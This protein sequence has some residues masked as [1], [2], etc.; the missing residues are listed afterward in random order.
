MLQLIR[1]RVTSIF[2]KALFVLLIASFAV[3]GI[4]DIFLGSPTGKAAIEVGNVEI[5]TAEVLDEFERV[6]RT[7]GLQMTAQEAA[8]IGLL[9]QVMDDLA[10]RALFIAES[11]D[12]GLAVGE[13]L[14]RQRIGEMPAFKDQTG[15][16]NPDL[17]R[18]VLYRAQ[19][20]EDGFVRLLREEIMRD[21]IV[22]AVTAGV[23]APAVATDVLYRYRNERR[24]AQLVTL[25][26]K[27][28]P[29]PAAPTD[30]Q[31]DS[32]YNDNKERYRAPEYRSA[33]VLSLT[34]EAL[35]ADIEV[36]EDRLRESYETRLDEF[37]SEAQRTVDQIF[38][39]DKETAD[40]AAAA[41]NEGQS[42]EAV[43][44][45]IAD[46]PAGA[47]SL[48]TVTRTDLD[49]TA[50]ADSI[51]S[52]ELNVP[53]A[54]VE[55]DLGW[56]IFRITDI[57]EESTQP[58]ADVKEQLKADIAQND[59]LDRIFEIANQIEDALA[60]GDTIEEAAKAVDVDVQTFAALDDQG[61][62]A[63]G[64]QTGGVVRDPSF[65]ATLFATPLND[66]SQL[67]ETRDGGYFI[68]RV[69]G[70][71]ES[72][73]RPLDAVKEQVKLNYMEEQRA[74]ANLLRAQEL[75]KASA[76]G[77]LAA[78]A[79]TAGYDVVTT[80]PFARTGDGLPEGAPADVA[81]IAFS[82]KVGDIGMSEDLTEVYITELSAIQGAELSDGAADPL[83]QQL[84]AGIASDAV[85]ILVTALRKSH[86]VSI[87]P[88]LPLSVIQGV[89]QSGGSYTQ[90]SGG[91]F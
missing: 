48:G 21:Q 50:L 57:A 84:K 30:S 89:D 20:S 13:D 37:R 5:T 22:N 32:F 19:L 38:L 61:R 39:A 31:L 47:L 55:S 41:L 11:D 82:L 9:D 26:V 85:E 86:D 88:A 40:K 4:G 46:L 34:A 53:T 65:R 8:E 76:S 91:L 14:V 60:G 23:G 74:A 71:A 7:T 87:N 66:Q 49:G 35:A 2:V 73:I 36:S 80:E 69:D 18:Q 90:Q 78:A 29:E 15:Q 16:F 72:A 62:D 67:E 51:F 64:N 44:K 17:F 27:S 1:S 68:L 3:W 42:F 12:L 28:L 24:V 63:D 33:T 79:A 43:A 6:R 81:E 75:V 58:F 56:H 70:I 77:G 52:A 25:D 59:A 54:P 10:N 45:D 83:G